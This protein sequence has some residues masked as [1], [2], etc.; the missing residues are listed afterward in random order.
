MDIG[1]NDLTV[2]VFFQCIHGEIRIIDVYADNGKGVDFY[3]HHLQQEKRYLYH[4]IFLPH[5]S[6]KRDGLIVENTYEREFKKLFSH[7]ETRVVVLKLTDK[8]ILLS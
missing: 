1:V 2:I 8:N 4:T 6:R 5:D 7:T 3:C